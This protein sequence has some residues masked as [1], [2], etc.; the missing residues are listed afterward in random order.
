MFDDQVQGVTMDRNRVR[1][2]TMMLVLCIILPSVILGW[3]DAEAQSGSGPDAT[4]AMT[5]GAAADSTGSNPVVIASESAAADQAGACETFGGAVTV[6]DQSTTATVDVQCTGGILDGMV[7]QNGNDG[8]VCTSYR[9]PTSPEENPSVTPTG[10][11]V[12]VQVEP[13]DNLEDAAGT[14]TTPVVAEDPTGTDTVVIANQVGNPVDLAAMQM[15]MCRLAGGKATTAEPVRTTAQGLS[16]NVGCTGGLLDGMICANTSNYSVCIFIGVA[17]EE[18]RVT[19]AA[20]IDVEPAAPTAEPVPTGVSAIPTAPPTEAPPMP[21]AAA[22][23]TP[24]EPTA[25]TED[26]PVFPTVATDDDTVPPG[27]GEDPTNDEPSPTE[28][29]LR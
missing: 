18:P 8:S 9:G 12:F 13:L 23:E 20:G 21:T 24:P 15:A 27:E 10:G 29:P 19:P 25:V 26:P 16:Q 3:R 6:I 17:P 22:T 2:K 11:I 14:S 28:A 5:P 1:L 4:V 7:C